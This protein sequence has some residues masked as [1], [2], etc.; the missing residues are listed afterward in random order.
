MPALPVLLH[1]LATAAAEPATVPSR[2]IPPSVLVELQALDNRFELYLSADCPPERCSSNGCAYVDHAVAD[3]PRERSLPGLGQDPGPGA[4]E[5]QAYLT[6]ARCSFSHEAAVPSADAAAMV[7]RLETRLSRGWTVVSVDRAALPPIPSTLE[8]A[9]EPEAPPAPPP[10]EAPPPW[11]RQLWDALLPHA[12]WMIGLGLGTLAGVALVWAW[13]RVGKA[14]LEEQV[15]LEQLRQPGEG[16]ASEEGGDASVP[17]RPD[18]AEAA[19][20]ATQEARWRTRLAALDPARPDPELVALV[21]ERLRAGD[22]PLLAKAVLR[23]PE[24]FPAAF[25]SEGDTA[26]AKLELAE[27]LQTVS[28]A[29]LPSDAA[30][31]RALERHALAAAL[32]WQPDA[33]VVR[34]LRQDFGSAGLGE[35]IGRVPARMG[36]LLFA[37]APPSE[38]H[39]VARLLNERQVAGLSQQLLASNRMDPG[40][41]A[42]LF[43][44]LRG[45]AGDAED[46][47][48]LPAEVTDR[49]TTFD[50]AGALAVLLPLLA[51]ARRAALFEEALARF[52][53][54]LPLWHR[55]IFLGD[56]LL[57]LEQEAR[58]DLLLEVEL[59]PLAA[60]LSLLEPDLRARLLDGVPE[61]L[62][63]SLRA[64]GAPHARAVQLALATRGRRALAVGF[65][66]QLARA[67]IPFEGVVRLRAA[68]A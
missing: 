23:F 36:A 43:E 1:L 2:Q 5:T 58:T 13:R 10:V 22:L 15:L 20:V 45:A 41:I 61:S 16:S 33:R 25:P 35:L 65:Q 24:S 27:L 60:W 59:E 6:R 52:Q 48:A 11:T 40:E 62:R 4:T 29:D 57:S 37:L 26:A 31:F 42:A 18:D 21:R 49:G 8:P 39:E 50:A 30:F 53:G 28:D 34:A 66:R 17:P 67:G 55:E 54:H 68:A 64:V 44:L 47:V 63:T 14:T 46:P 9:P 19:Y 38:Q 56:M 32:A 7:R 3:Q 51:P 12:W